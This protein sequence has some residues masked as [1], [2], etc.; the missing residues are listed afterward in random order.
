MQLL[1]SERDTARRRT[2]ELRVENDALKRESEGR[3]EVLHTMMLQ[4]GR[5]CYKMSAMGILMKH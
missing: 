3:M 1:I 4:V 5:R 2:D